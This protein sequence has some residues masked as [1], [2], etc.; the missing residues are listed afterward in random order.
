M[1]AAG[2]RPGAG[3]RYLSPLGQIWRLA[4]HPPV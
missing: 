3:V 1:S 2:G 4:Q